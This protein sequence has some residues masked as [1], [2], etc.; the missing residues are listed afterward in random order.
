MNQFI[1]IENAIPSSMEMRQGMKAHIAWKDVDQLE[2][3]S[4]WDIYEY[5][6]MKV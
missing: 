6:N 2:I 3:S 5:E 4:D 1:Y